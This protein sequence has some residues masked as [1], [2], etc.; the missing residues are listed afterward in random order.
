MWRM[1][2]DSGVLGW[3]LVAMAILA[4]ILFIERLIAYRRESTDMEKFAPRFRE[5]VGAG[6]WDEAAQLCEQHQG[7]IAEVFRL[8]VEHRRQGPATL[9]N[10]LNNHIDLTVLPRLRARLR[11]LTALGKGAPM[12]G[13]LGTVQGMMGAF[14]TIAGAEGQGA[15]PKALAGDI[16]LALGT[17]FLGLLIAIPVMFATAYLRS[18]VEQFEIDLEGYGDSCL[19]GLFPQHPPTVAPET[20]GV[21][22]SAG[23]VSGKTPS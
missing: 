23:T 21:A 6:R 4:L 16:G 19:D 9:R 12:V 10:I 8:A 7:H 14:T 1:I 2:L 15:D 11:P 5:A 18:R 3:T 17:T 22:A 20:L 13:L